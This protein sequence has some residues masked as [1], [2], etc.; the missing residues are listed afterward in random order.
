MKQ[1]EGNNLIVG[2]SQRDKC[3]VQLS[4]CHQTGLLLHNNVCGRNESMN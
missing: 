3:N 1:I 2:A 4:I